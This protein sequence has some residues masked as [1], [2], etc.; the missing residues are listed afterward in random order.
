MKRMEKKHK[1]ILLG[2][3]GAPHGVRGEVRVKSFTEDPVAL[4]DYGPLTTASGR[5]LEISAIRPS[6]T[7]VVVRFKGLDSR[8]MAEA[9][10]GEKLY[11]ER[12]ALPD[13]DAGED[14]FY[15][16]DLVGLAV[17]DASDAEIGRISAVYDHGAG[18]L[19]EL[20]LSDGRK[21]PLP[22]TSGYVPVVDIAGGFVR[23][24]PPAGLF[25]DAEPEGDPSEEAGVS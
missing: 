25:D 16:T 7:V 5:S 6:K 12:D 23:I 15:Y 14:E 18:D 19:L 13:A 17:T 1:A 21:I 4:G 20:H 24:A 2:Q 10:K 9:L 11:V 8:T 22:F 3:I